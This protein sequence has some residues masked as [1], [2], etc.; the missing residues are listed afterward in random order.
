MWARVSPSNEILKIIRHAKPIT[1]DGIQHP[2]SIFNLWSDAEKAAIGIYPVQDTGHPD[3]HFY[4]WGA[5]TSTFNTVTKVVEISY[6]ATEKSLNDTLWTSQDQTDGAIPTKK[7]VGD[8][9]TQGLKND[10]ITRSK[11]IAN[12]LLSST[13]WYV[14]RSTERSK[15]IPSVV[16]TYRAAVISTLD[17]METKIK[18][19]A[20]FSVFKALYENEY[21]ANATLKAASVIHTWPDSLED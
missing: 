14:T 6:S 15:A 3:S 2:R 1:I 5:P 17:T 8:V 20:T 19:A 13:D 11:Q 21:Y 10:Q 9:K 7:S 16:N 4:T 18:D 12:S